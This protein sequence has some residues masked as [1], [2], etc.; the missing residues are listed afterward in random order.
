MH[1]HLKSIQNAIHQ[2]T[3]RQL[4]ALTLLSAAVLLASC[5]G[6]KTPDGTPTAAFSVT[7]SAAL[8]PVKLD[9][10]ASTDP[11]ND[12][13]TYRWELGDGQVATGKTVQTAYPA[14]TYAVKLTVTDAGG[15]SSSTTKNVTVTSPASTG[16]S[17]VRVLVVNDT[18]QALP[19]A[20]VTIDG[21]TAVADSSGVA[22]LRVGTG[23]TT[24]ISAK[25]VGH[26]TLLRRKVF[27]TPTGPFPEAGDLYAKLVL[28]PQANAVT[29]NATT[30]GTV[31]GSDGAQVTFP[32]NALVNAAGQAVTGNV[33]V[34]VTPSTKADATFP[35]GGAALDENGDE[36]LL[37]TYGMLDVQITQGGQK[38]Q[39][40]PGKQA[41]LGLHLTA[42]KHQDGAVINVGDKVP[43]WWFNES[44]GL[45]IQ[46][47]EGEVVAST[48]SSSG[49]A[50]T[51]SVS[52]FTQWNWDMKVLNKT[53]LAVKCM[54]LDPTTQLPTVPLSAGET[55]MLDGVIGSAG[56]V[57]AASST[58]VGAAG[59]TIVNVPL[60]QPM[61]LDA[62]A[63]GM[64][65]SASVTLGSGHLD[66][67]NPLIIPLPTP[68]N[69]TGLSFRKSSYVATVDLNYR[70]A[71]PTL[72]QSTNTPL[73]FTYTVGGQ[74]LPMPTCGA[75]LPANGVC[76][77]GLKV[78][79]PLVSMMFS[80]A[81]TPN[82][83]YT[84]TASDGTN[85]ASTDVYVQ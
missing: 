13:L 57:T 42:N 28:K 9:A 26:V 19:G 66:I 75:I 14:G 10:S 32:P 55:C 64:S 76:L 51:M 53:T 68:L 84:I 8:Q 46:E 34:S 6:P 12:A 70:F 73:T 4:S 45:W 82:T 59:T 27:P 67:T 81:N 83:T 17:T 52:H 63:G 37:F 2:N 69:V 35:G 49:K 77:H 7:G 18:G 39:L 71:N 65:G 58:I 41:K 56:S 78:S 29:L 54:Y 20:Q 33:Q 23:V 11:T 30:G 80:L 16:K 60:G 61:T 48:T 21:Q 5:G 44:S 3:V 25:Y 62:Y 72:L 50:L 40:A 36:T 22:K 15:L 24:T 47:G 74:T 43:A 79:A 1:S 31:T 85:T 38:L